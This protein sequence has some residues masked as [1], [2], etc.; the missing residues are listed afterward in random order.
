MT[1]KLNGSSSGS[2]SIDAPASTTGGADI[3]FNLPVADGSSGQA[4]TTNASGQLAFASIV[5]GKLLQHVYTSSSQNVTAT[6]T[7]ALLTVSITP[8]ATSSKIL[9]LGYIQIWINASSNAFGAGILYRGGITDTQ[10]VRKYGGYDG[11][12]SFA[13]PCTMWHLDSPSTTSATTY[14]LAIDK[15]SS[16]TTSAGTDSKLHYLLAAEIGA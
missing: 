4:L 11:P 1:L 6:S 8:S 15:N 13:L 9:L 10:L 5:G 14:T 16:N 2:V 3:T 12:A 7:T